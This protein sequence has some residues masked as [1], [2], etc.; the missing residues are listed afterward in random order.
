L[1]QGRQR[2]HLGETV[3]VDV[4]LKLQCL[5]LDLQEIVLA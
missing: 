5:Q 2:L 3:R 1:A 4:C